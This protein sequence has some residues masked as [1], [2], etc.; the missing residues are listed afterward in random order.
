[1]GRQCAASA[2]SEKCIKAFE[3]GMHAEEAKNEEITNGL[4]P[5]EPLGLHFKLR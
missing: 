1:M 3:E 2:V 4:E 5:L